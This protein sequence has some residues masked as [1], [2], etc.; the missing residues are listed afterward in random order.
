MPPDYFV[1][2][3]LEPCKRSGRL[4]PQIQTA[5]RHKSEIEHHR[6]KIRLRAKR[7]GH[8]EFP[9]LDE[10]SSGDTRERHRVYRRAQ[11][12]IDK[13]L[14]PTASVPSVFIEPRKRWACCR[15]KP[16]ED[17]GLPGG[18]NPAWRSPVGKAASTPVTPGVGSRHSRFSCLLEFSSLK[19]EPLPSQT[20][21]LG[22]PSP[23]SSSC[24]PP[25]VV[26]ASRAWWMLISFPTAA[27]SLCRLSLRPLPLKGEAFSEGQLSF[28]SH[29]AH[30]WAGS[31][32]Y[33][34][35]PRVSTQLLPTEGLAALPGNSFIALQT[36][37]YVPFLALGKIPAAPHTPSTSL[38]I[39]YFCWINWA[40]PKLLLP[41]QDL[42]Q[43][44][45][46]SDD[47]ILYCPVCLVL[48]AQVDCAFLRAETVSYTLFISGGV[49]HTVARRS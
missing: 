42:G 4:A 46:A 16:L 43:V 15:G 29:W 33:L 20:L 14:D 37:I 45:V 38:L 12:Q 44:P 47:V 22:S 17:S 41:L 39:Y 35:G 32:L 2:G 49:F 13:I 9:V 8:Y 48:S 21:S 18:G 30:P 6:N 1:R 3:F 27:L 23:L 36:L 28:V 40:Y 19:W 10:L 26:T 25:S 24:P 7:R 34:V 11:M 5:L 31:L